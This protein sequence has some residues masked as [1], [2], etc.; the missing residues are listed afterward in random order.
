M[1]ELEKDRD[2]LT[3]EKF[4][5]VNETQ[6]TT[7]LQ[8]Y[9]DKIS[10]LSKNHIIPLNEQFTICANEEAALHK[11]QISHDNKKH[12][13]IEN[14][15]KQNQNLRTEN[16]FSKATALDLSQKYATLQEKHSRLINDN[17]ELVTRQ[18][19]QTKIIRTLE[20]QLAAGQ[21][22]ESNTEL[23]KQNK[24]L[25]EEQDT[26]ADN[27]KKLQEDHENLRIKNNTLMSRQLH[28]TK[29]ITQLETTL[30]NQKVELD[31]IKKNMIDLSKNLESQYNALLKK[32]TSLSKQYKELVDYSKEVEKKYDDLKVVHSTLKNTVKMKQLENTIKDTQ[33]SVIVTTRNLT[34]QV[35]PVVN[36]SIPIA[37]QSKDAISLE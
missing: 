29:I 1:V 6:K 37:P 12:D 4:K 19:E 5:F 25:L 26:I 28:Q 21:T 14:F 18:L 7:V 27:Y 15:A 8:A 34:Q 3:K 22:K 10:L 13:L 20:N 36:A 33:P 2:K 31:V 32:Y 30:E 16:A 11:K 24:L 9:N 17:N 35:T 23:A